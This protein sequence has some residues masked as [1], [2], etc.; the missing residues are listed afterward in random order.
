MLAAQHEDT[1]DTKLHEEK[2]K[3]GEEFKTCKKLAIQAG[4]VA[5]WM[6]EN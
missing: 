6:T 4:G 2:Q 1:K 5:C 3:I